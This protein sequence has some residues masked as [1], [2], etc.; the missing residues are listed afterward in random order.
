[1]LRWIFF[2]GKSEKYFFREFFPFLT[3]VIAG[4]VSLA[5]LRRQ[6]GGVMSADAS[7]RLMQIRGLHRFFIPDARNCAKQ[8]DCGKV[9]CRQ[10]SKA[11]ASGRG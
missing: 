8:R 9:D 2:A 7:E 10:E 1:M 6:T 5:D 4:G 3:E 11:R